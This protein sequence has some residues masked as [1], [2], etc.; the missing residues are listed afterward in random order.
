MLLL[1]LSKC[2]SD[3]RMSWMDWWWWSLLRT[4]TSMWL[5]DNNLCM[6]KEDVQALHVVK[7]GNSTGFFICLFCMSKKL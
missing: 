4:M 2:I 3:V 5:A 7:V 6:I 1:L